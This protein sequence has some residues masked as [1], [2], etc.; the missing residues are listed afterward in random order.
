[1]L[2]HRFF[3]HSQQQQQQQQKMELGPCRKAHSEEL[4]SAYE[5]ARKTHDYGYEMA[6]LE[7][8]DGILRDVD[9]KT[10]KAKQR[11]ETQQPQMSQPE[12]SVRTLQ[13]KQQ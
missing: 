12:L 1:L 13:N 4:R 6:L 2:F 3:L 9:R 7:Q 5:E 10:V 8:L 11:L